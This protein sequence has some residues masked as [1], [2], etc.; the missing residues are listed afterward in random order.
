MKRRIL[1][2]EAVLATA[3]FGASVLGA[4]CARKPV[5]AGDSIR[6]VRAVAVGRAQ[7]PDEIEGFGNLS[8]LKKVDVVSPSDAV[9]RSLPFR[10]GK[11][12]GAASI[13][14][15]LENPQIE[16]AVGR[17]ENALSQAEAALELAEANLCEGKFA[18]EA[19]L[20]GLAKSEAELAAARRELAEAERKQADQ[21]KLFEAGGVTEEA[22]RGGRFSL[23][24]GRD[25]I[26]IRERALE[27]SR[28]GF[29]DA[30][31]VA[32]GLASESGPPLTETGRLAALIELSTRSLSAE[33][34]AAGA[35]RDAARKELESARLAQAELLV[36]APISALVG[37]L[38]VEE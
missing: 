32:A 22:I 29:R 6:T 21:E 19:R 28:V 3:A 26:A 20:L 8:Y 33:A 13:V 15:L 31:L 23:E 16:L 17:A 11:G 1:M 34:A 38:Y 9:V 30:D 35:R 7:I 18:A 36:I 4:A 10:E 24:S 25:G 27:I 2:A 5:Q 37:A 14:A 12:V